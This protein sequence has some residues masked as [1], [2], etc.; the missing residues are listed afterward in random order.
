MTLVLIEMPC[1]CGGRDKYCPKCGGRGFLRS[2][3]TQHQLARMGEIPTVLGATPVVV[4]KP[5]Q[6]KRG[7]RV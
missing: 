6:K 2:T 5:R 7:A 1:L 4:R 3:I